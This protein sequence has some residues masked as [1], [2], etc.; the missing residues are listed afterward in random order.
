MALSTF[1]GNAV[2]DALLNNVAL[3]K[4][5]YCSLH[6]ADPAL[7]GASELSGNGYAR[8][9]VTF[10]VPDGDGDTQNTA[11]V[12]FGPASADWTAATYFGLWDQLA[13]GGNF[14]GGAALDTPRTVLNGQYAEFAIG[15]EDIVGATQFGNTTLDNIVNALF[16]N[17]ALQVAQ[18]YATLHTADP[19]GTGASELPDLESYARVAL[20]FAAAASKACANDVQTDFAAAGGDGW[21]EVTHLGLW[22]LG[23][24]GGGTFLWGKQ[25]TVPRIVTV[26]KFFRIAVGGVNVNVA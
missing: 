14:L 16:R 12:T 9:A 22:T 11:A 19:G 4:T 26:G 1:A 2:L 5:P 21:A 25:L 3:Q 7:T 23:T 15:V 20:S 6:S 10:D 17:T 13:V 8:V 24:Y 18:A